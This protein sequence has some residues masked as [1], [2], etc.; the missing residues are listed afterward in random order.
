MLAEMVGHFWKDLSLKELWQE[1]RNTQE[2]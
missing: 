1:P 2:L